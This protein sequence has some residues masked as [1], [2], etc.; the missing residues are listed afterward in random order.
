MEIHRAGGLAAG[1]PAEHANLREARKAKKEFE[2][3]ITF[4]TIAN[5]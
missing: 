3:Q 2:I 4:H 1:Y 5:Q